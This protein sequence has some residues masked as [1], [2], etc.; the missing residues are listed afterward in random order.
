MAGLFGNFGLARRLEKAEA[1]NARHLAGILDVAGGVAAFAGPSSPLTH[2]LGAGMNGPVSADELDRIE[3]FYREQDSPVVIELC[4]LAD[5][6]LFD[7][8]GRRAYRI[9]EFNNVLVR[10]LDAPPADVVAHVRRAEPAEEDLWAR[11]VSEGFFERSQFTHEELR[12]TSMLFH[13]PGGAPWLAFVDRQAAAAAGMVVRDGLATL[14]GDA[15]VKAFRRRGLQT[16]LIR[17]RLLYAI[18]RGCDL[19]TASTLPGSQSQLNYERLGF[20]V[21]Y[22]KLI[23]T[24]E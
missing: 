24:N 7:L 19:A 2:A 18:E 15:T 10:T 20:R 23:L 5:P 17:A 22:T 4:P 13:L 11:T 1:D 12:M 8:L 14:F 16:E 3:A 6:S 21:V 9:T